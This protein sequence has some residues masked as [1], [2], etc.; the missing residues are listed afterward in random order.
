MPR[1][2]SFSSLTLLVVALRRSRRAAPAALASHG[3]TVYFEAS[4]DL[5]EP[6][7]PRRKRSNRCSTSA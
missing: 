5:L 4:T 2:R 7:H 6:S 1:I 3:Q